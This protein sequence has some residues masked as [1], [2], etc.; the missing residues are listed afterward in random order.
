MNETMLHIFASLGSAVFNSIWQAGLIWL[1]VLVYIKTEK[2]KKTYCIETLAFWAVVAGF[3]SFLTS[4]IYTCFFTHTQSSVFVG[5]IGLYGLAHLLPYVAMAYLCFLI[6]PLIRLITGVKTIYVFKNRRLS[7]VPGHLKIFTLNGSSWLGIRR[8]VKIF[9]SD[10]ATSPLT[11]GWLRPMILIPLAAI[12]NLS[13]QQV[14]A[15]ILHELAHIKRNDYLKNFINQLILAFMYFNPF[16]RALIK[17]QNLEREKSADD[18]VV[19]F[20]YDKTL[21]ATALYSIA[22]YQSGIENELT[23]AASGKNSELLH[24]IEF[25]LGTKRKNLPDLKKVI[26][27][28]ALI[29]FLAIIS[30]LKPANNIEQR[31]NILHVAKDE[32]FKR[33]PVAFFAPEENTELKNFQAP[34]KEKLIKQKNNQPEPHSIH[35]EDE[36]LSDNLSITHFASSVTPLLTAEEEKNIETSLYATKKIL[37]ETIW[38]QIE[39]QF[40][41]T[42]TDEQKLILKKRFEQNFNYT[43]WNEIETN[44]RQN[45]YYIDWANVNQRLK[46]AVK[47]IQLDSLYKNY[48]V[49]QQKLLDIKKSVAT[50]VYNPVAEYEQADIDKKLASVNQLLGYIEQ[51]RRQRIIE[52]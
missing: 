51:L 48:S 4:F 44:L 31:T 35:S 28:L 42:M 1:L 14:E 49:T 46:N 17:I 50:D 24:R 10:I 22:S 41:E 45:Y 20:E 16:I 15:I 26:F 6:F 13:T 18:W 21:Y 3:L 27:S 9:I 38:Q 11:L 52:L 19:R 33:E 8:K 39:F 23:I 43:N 30:I 37:S 47:S 25:L 34:K 32:I 29:T 7:K 36:M 5:I 2:V 40:A 12:N